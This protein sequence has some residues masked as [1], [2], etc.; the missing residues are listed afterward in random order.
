MG[1]VLPIRERLLARGLTILPESLPHRLHIITV[2]EHVVRV[3]VELLLLPPV[4]RHVIPPKASHIEAEFVRRGRGDRRRHRH[5]FCLFFSRIWCPFPFSFSFSMSLRL[6]GLGVRLLLR[7]LLIC[8][9]LRLV[10]QLAVLI[11]LPAHLAEVGCAA[12]HVDE[13]EDVVFVDA[14]V[15]AEVGHREVEAEARRLEGV[16]VRKAVVLSVG[17]VAALAGEYVGRGCGGGGE[18]EVQEEEEERQEE[19][20][21]DGERIHPF[22]RE[23]GAARWIERDEVYGCVGG[24]VEW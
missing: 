8:L 22:S 6:L 16:A 20:G 21:G 12:L 15:L 1:H 3:G 5:G 11:E 10:D 18:G 9:D 4:Q 14:R 24:W 17:A 7:G 2:D 13:V 19:G 23:R